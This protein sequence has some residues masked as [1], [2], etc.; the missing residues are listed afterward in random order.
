M[1]DF[2]RLIPLPPLRHV[3]LLLHEMGSLPLPDP[4][5]E[6]N[7]TNQSRQH[8]SNNECYADYPSLGRAIVGPATHHELQKPTNRSHKQPGPPRYD[9]WHSFSSL[10]HW[11]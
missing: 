3:K 8:H 1:R 4:F 7:H 5:N 2:M 11:R 9:R 6:A 10:D